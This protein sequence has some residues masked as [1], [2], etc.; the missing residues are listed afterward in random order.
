[1][2]CHSDTLR[3][4]LHYAVSRVSFVQNKQTEPQIIN[5]IDVIPSLSVYST[6][7]CNAY[8]NLCNPKLPA[9]SFVIWWSR[10]VANC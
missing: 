3:Y 4:L 2:I 8:L 1:V 5:I 10:S 9:L 7:R 6:I